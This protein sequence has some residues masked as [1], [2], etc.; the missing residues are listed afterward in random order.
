M[1]RNL[2]MPAPARPRV[3]AGNHATGLLKLIALFFMF[4]DHSGKVLFHNN[5]DMRLLGRIAFPIYVWCMIVGFHYTRSVPKYLLRVLIVGLASQP[6]YNL[7][8]HHTWKE[9]NV[10]LCLF[11]GLCALWGIREKKFLSHVF[12]GK[13]SLLINH[14][15]DS[16]EITLKEM[17]ELMEM[18]H[19]SEKR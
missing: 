17:D 5:P 13:A 10:F 4:I 8:L 9:P 3:P 19:K 2:S 16:G 11:L 7:A 6:L 18:L 15:V 14:L 1:N 12:S